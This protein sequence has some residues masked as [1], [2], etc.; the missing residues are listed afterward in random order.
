MAKAEN[1]HTVVAATRDRLAD[2]YRRV[3]SANRRPE[4]DIRSDVLEAMHS[5][6]LPHWV[7]RTIRYRPRPDG[8]AKSEPL[9]MEVTHNA[10]MPPEVLE[11]GVAGRG[12]LHIDWRN[13]RA[14]RRTG[15]WEGKTW[16]RIEFEGIWC[17]RA[18]ELLWP[19]EVTPEPTT[20]VEAPKPVKTRSK[21]QT[22]RIDAVARRLYPPDGRPPNNIG[23]TALTR[24]INV[25]LDPES[26]N[27]GIKNPSVDAVRRWRRSRFKD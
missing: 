20:A 27:L 6:K 22:D 17:S 10:P 21:F 7:E 1:D 11:I 19:I 25:E 23:N 26:R 16:D 15:R 12:S 24:A 2:V 4:A 8:A 13:S 14:T 18:H 9:S 3:V 5:G